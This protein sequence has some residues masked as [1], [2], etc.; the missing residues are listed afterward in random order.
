MV[1]SDLMPR[2][3]TAWYS[4]KMRSTSGLHSIRSTMGHLS[5]SGRSR[6]DSEMQSDG[7]YLPPR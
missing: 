6:R 5:S 1:G 2:R 3:F 4:L 7:E